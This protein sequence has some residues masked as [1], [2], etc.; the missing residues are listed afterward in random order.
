MKT[1]LLLDSSYP[2]RFPLSF[3]SRW[4]TF[5][6]NLCISCANSENSNVFGFL[7]KILDFNELNLSRALF[8]R[9]SPVFSIL[10]AGLLSH[11]NSLVE[12]A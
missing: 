2:C 5:V 3:V 7:I 12:V 4:Y 8:A 6:F 11:R 9:T 1:C 10:N